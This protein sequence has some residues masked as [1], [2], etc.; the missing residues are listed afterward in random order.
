MQKVISNVAE[1]SISKGCLPLMPIAHKIMM[2]EPAYFNVDTPINA[3]MFK[4]DG[5]LQ[6]V[7]KNKA[8]E[9]WKALKKLYES[10]GLSVYTVEP[11][12]GLPDMVFC[13]N[14]SFPYLDS[15]GNRY[16]VLSN[17]HNDVRN[18]EVSYINAFLT[19]QRYTTRQIASRTMGYF[20]ESMGDAL[21]LPGYKLIIG[22][23]GYRTDKRIYPILSEI[24]NASV[25]IF[26]L[27]NPK[28]Y[29]LDTCLSILNSTSAL[30]CK[31]AFTEEGWL[32]LKAIF[33]LLIEVPLEE[34]DSPNFACNAH[35]PDGKHVIIQKGCRKSLKML[36]NFNFVPL[37][38]DTSEFIKSGGSVFCMKLMF[39]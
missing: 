25:A 36:K 22:G 11:I 7:D 39:F 38:L 20:F 5:S 12:K 23:Y 30:A 3:H 17:M 18:N 31:K 24:T 28:F 13:A 32:L 27:K 33:P 34:A 1:L 9:Q 4:H 10:I 15:C 29:H 26:E 8:I 2:V 6:I 19:E 21:W 37:E 35:C 14:Q 16:A